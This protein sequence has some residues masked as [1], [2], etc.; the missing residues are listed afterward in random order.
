MTERSQIMKN[1]NKAM[2][3]TYPNR[4]GNNLHE[5]N[6]ILENKFMNVFG[7]IHILPFYPSSGDDGFAP[8]TYDQVDD[9]FGSWTDIESLGKKIP[10]DGG[11]HDQS[12]I[13][14]IA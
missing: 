11:S 9:Q 8:I 5:L 13:T 3:I 6:Q 4:L 10:I 14:T 12:L 7:A 2:L 1:T